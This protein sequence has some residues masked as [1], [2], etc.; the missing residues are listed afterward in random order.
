VYQ[1]GG[2]CASEG[3][4][5]PLVAALAG[6]TE[7]RSLH[8][9]PYDAFSAPAFEQLA[10]AL[11]RTHMRLV[12][13]PNVKEFGAHGHAVVRLLLPRLELL[14]VY[15]RNYR[16]N[17]VSESTDAALHCLAAALRDGRA[18]RLRELRFGMPG[19]GAAAVHAAL[20]FTQLR[21][22]QVYTNSTGEHSNSLAALATFLPPSLETLQVTDTSDV[23][24]WRQGRD[25]LFAAAAVMP[26][27]AHLS[28]RHFEDGLEFADDDDD[29]A[30]AHMML[31]P[32]AAPALRS[33]HLGA[34]LGLDIRGD[35]G[36]LLLQTASALGANDSLT[37]LRV[38]K[39]QLGC[40]TLRALGAA[41]RRNTA[42]RELSITMP[43]PFSIVGMHRLADGLAA[44]TG[45]THFSFTLLLSLGDVSYDDDEYVQKITRWRRELAPAAEALERCAT[46]A[47][48]VEVLLHDAA[49]VC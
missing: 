5:A 3:A 33:L 29:K 8:G 6:C 37:Q 47:R 44:N 21:V 36:R 7:L 38:K 18:T 25:K 48:T 46:S 20:A 9:L 17:R 31:Q 16:H 13:L 35:S 12:H 32:G 10:A 4:T 49:G 1:N 39:F 22:L 14:H 40:T 34:G 26:S 28:I 15:E 41:L 19:A 11:S 23:R 24:T 43:P 42:L 2:A 45:L 30:V 27:L